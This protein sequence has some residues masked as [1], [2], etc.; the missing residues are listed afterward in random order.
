VQKIY[1]IELY[2]HFEFKKKKKIAKDEQLAKFQQS[3][4][5]FKTQLNSE[6]LID[7]NVLTSIWN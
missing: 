3:R 6:V 1:R 5:N 2:R 7:K 4:R